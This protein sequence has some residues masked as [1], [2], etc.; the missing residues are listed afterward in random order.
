MLLIKQV[1]I[2]LSTILPPSGKM[3]LIWIKGVVPELYTRYEVLEALSY[4]LE[5]KYTREVAESS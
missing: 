2:L 4:N 3:A 5:R 1:T